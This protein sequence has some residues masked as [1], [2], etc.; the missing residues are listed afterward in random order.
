LLLRLAYANSR[1][2]RLPVVV[3]IDAGVAFVGNIG[4]TDYFD[5]TVVGD[6]VNMAKRFQDA[7]S[8]GELLVGETAFAAVADRYANCDYST[9]ACPEGC[10]V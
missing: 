7:A 9:P 3:V 8:P 10:R 2:A 1:E 4:G 5:F 6:P